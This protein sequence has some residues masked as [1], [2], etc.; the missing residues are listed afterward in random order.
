MHAAESNDEEGSGDW[1]IRSPGAGGT[2]EA[3]GGPVGLCRTGL[4]QGQ[5][6]AGE[7]GPL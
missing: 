3:Q 1:C 7:T 6:R 4:L 5:R 2:E